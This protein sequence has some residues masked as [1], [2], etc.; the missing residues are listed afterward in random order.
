MKQNCLIKKL[1]KFLGG[2]SP[3]QMEE[4]SASKV[5]ELDFAPSRTLSFSLDFNTEIACTGSLSF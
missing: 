1:W 5:S 2:D 3:K 4:E